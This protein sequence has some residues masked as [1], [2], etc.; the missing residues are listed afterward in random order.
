MISTYS[1]LISCAQSTRR[2]TVCRGSP[3]VGSLSTGPG[4]NS[5]ATLS[6]QTSSEGFLA[7][8]QLCP[9]EGG[10]ATGARDPALVVTLPVRV[11]QLDLYPEEQKCL[12]NCHFASSPGTDRQFPAGLCRVHQRW[13]NGPTLC[14]GRNP[15]RKHVTMRGDSSL[16]LGQVAL[17]H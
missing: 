14:P 1:C 17:S 9:E 16:G 7:F 5:T 10:R 2:Q 13:R 11:R 15:Q 12:R 6:T 8:T 4:T 3:S